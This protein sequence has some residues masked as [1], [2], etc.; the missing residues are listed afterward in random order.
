MQFLSHS[1]QIRR[2]VYGIDFPDDANVNRYFFTELQKLFSR[3]QLSRWTPVDTSELACAL[4]MERTPWRQLMPPI[5]RVHI[6]LEEP[7]RWLGTRRK[8]IQV[9]VVT[10]ALASDE[11]DRSGGRPQ[12]PAATVSLPA[13]THRQLLVLHHRHGRKR[14]E[15]SGS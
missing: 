9:D 7:A 11:K 13:W 3:L 10:Q 6:F 15:Q 2:L 8:V 1:P 5:P 12:H 14:S 4:G